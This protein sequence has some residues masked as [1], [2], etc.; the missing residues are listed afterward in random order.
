MHFAARLLQIID[1]STDFLVAAVSDDGDRDGLDRA[2]HQNQIR[3]SPF[4]P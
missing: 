1:S 4:Q 3:V 2:R